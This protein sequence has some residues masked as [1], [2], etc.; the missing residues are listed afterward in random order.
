MGNDIISPESMKEGIESN[1][2][3]PGTVVAVVKPNSRTRVKLPQ[4]KG[5]ST[6]NNF[7]YEG[8]GKM[9]VFQS[10][11]VGVGKLVQI[12][13]SEYFVPLDP[14]VGDGMDFN[15]E[16]QNSHD[17]AFAPKHRNV[18]LARLCP[19]PRCSGII[20]QGEEAS[21]EHQ[22][23][24]LPKEEMFGLDLYKQQWAEEILGEGSSLRGKSVYEVS[25]IGSVFVPA[26]H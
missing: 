25:Q 21:H 2:G 7:V 12:K 3:L 8:D 10:Y 16:I 23:D 22:I 19:H 11:S 26:H 13:G 20:L 9:R 18:S 15:F 1:G 24:Q 5:I 14:I 17:T 6:Y 4:L